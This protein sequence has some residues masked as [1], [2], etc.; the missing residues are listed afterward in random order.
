[1]DAANVISLVALTFSF[2]A[3][4]VYVSV[5]FSKLET[6]VNY[7]KSHYEDFKTIREMVYRIHAQ[8]EILLSL[9][10]S[11]LPT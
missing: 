3:M 11:N 6:E 4:V 5:R 1:M 10:Q 2:L 8:N 7:L 9:K